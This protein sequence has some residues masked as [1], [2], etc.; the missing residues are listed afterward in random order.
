MKTKDK[1]PSRIQREIQEM[2]E[3]MHAHGLMDEAAYKKITLR[4]LQGDAAPPELQAPSPEEIRASREQAHM[5]QAAF[6][7]RLLLSAG[8]VAQRERGAKRPR[9]PLVVLLNV[10]RRQG[11]QAVL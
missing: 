3:E 5:S 2:A 10:L 4:D 9:G 8:F 1:P 7:K 6:A 11:I